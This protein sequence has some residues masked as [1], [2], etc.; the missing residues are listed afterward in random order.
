MRIMIK[1]LNKQTTVINAFMRIMIKELNKHTS[2]NK[3][4]KTKHVKVPLR[5]SLSL[6]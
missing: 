3:Q 6:L 5:H 1:E 4:Q 2:A